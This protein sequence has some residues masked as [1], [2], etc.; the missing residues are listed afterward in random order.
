M[1]LIDL[2][3]P[4][5]ESMPVYPGDPSTKIASGNHIQENGYEDHYLCIGTHAGTH[6]D[7]PSH[8][9]LYGKTLNQFPLE[10][11]TG[12]GV[13]VPVQNKRFD[14]SAIAAI[15][16]RENDIVLFHTG[17]NER[18]NKSD[19]FEEY[20]ALPEELVKYLIVKKVKMVG[21]DTCSVD[22][23]EFTSHR[24]LLQQDILILE[25]LTNLASLINKQFSV[26]AFP[27]NVQ[28][29]GSPVRVVAEIKES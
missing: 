8:M 28:L 18:Y 12:R 23:N 22:H 19:Y 27:I 21:V 1:Q 4:I 11:F 2:S 16:I 10:K 25:N 15:A 14:L 9:I 13:Y 20:P 29:D 7:A 6:I 26:S 5:I 24:L 17:M 3:H